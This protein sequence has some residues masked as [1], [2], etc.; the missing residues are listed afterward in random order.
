MS[1]DNEPD[2]SNES[3]SG[4]RKQLEAALAAQKASD[5]LLAGYVAKEMIASKGLKHVSAED[6]AQVPLSE[7]E[8]K[9]TELDAAKAAQAESLFRSTLASRGLEGDQLEQ[10]L[11][12]LL[13]SS[14]EPA[15]EVYG[16]IRSVGKVQAAPPASDIEKGLTG[17]DLIR[18]TFQKK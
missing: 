8:A 4:L 5:K 18:A 17:P 16:R 6:L 15:S 9:A 1:D 2:G 13:G 10:T 14:D 12:L 3:G 11:A 7:M